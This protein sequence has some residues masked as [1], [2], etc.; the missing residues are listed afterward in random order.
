[1]RYLSQSKKEIKQSMQICF[2]HIFELDHYYSIS[3]SG[4]KNELLQVANKKYSFYLQKENERSGWK[5]RELFDDPLSS[6]D[7]SQY[8]H[9]KFWGTGIVLSCLMVENCWINELIDSNTFE[10]L[11]VE[12]KKDSNGNNSEVELRFKSNHFADQMSKILGGTILLDP[13][14]YWVIKEYELEVEGLPTKNGEKSTFAIVK[15]IIDYQYIDNIPFPKKY[16]ICYKYHNQEVISHL[17]FDFTSV[18]RC[19]VPQ[20]IFSLKYYGFP[21]PSH[22]MRRGDVIRIILMVV[23][24]I[25]IL[26]SL[27]M[28]FLAKR[29]K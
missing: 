23:G 26:V 27:F 18:K 8:F 12:N 15:S 13:D 9:K 4:E 20:E 29:M 1:M 19:Q 17:V 6:K 28:R 21:E 11:S 22:P 5:V 7:S 16:D 24:T 10:L 25:L 2:D 14:H 3:R